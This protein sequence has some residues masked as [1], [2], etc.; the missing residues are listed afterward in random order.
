MQSQMRDYANVVIGTKVG[1]DWHRDK[2]F[3]NASRARIVREVD[4]SL[5]RLQT[6][7]IDVYQVHWPDPQ[8]SIEGTADAM[9][10]HV[11]NECSALLQHEIQ[12]RRAILVV[13]LTSGPVPVLTDRF[14]P[15]RR[16][17]SP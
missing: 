10:T 6:D 7:Y 8:V 3:R 1:L 14:G 15:T 13:E 9:Q 4:D 16:R 2:P 17:S 11:V 5:R 12:T